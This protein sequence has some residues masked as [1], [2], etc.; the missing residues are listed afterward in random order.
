[1]CPFPFSGPVPSNFINFEAVSETSVTIFLDLDKCHVLAEEV[2]SFNLWHRVAVTESY[3]STPTVIILAPLKTFPVTGLVPATSYVFKVVAYNKSNE[4]GSWEVKKKTSCKKEDQRGLMPVGAVLEGN[5]GSPKTNSDGQSDPSSEGVDSNNNTAVCA[6]LNKSPESDFEYCENPEILDSGKASHHPGE[7]MDGLQNIQM[8]AARVTEVIELEEAPGLSASVLDEEPNPITQTAL[9]RESSN[10]EEHNQ[11]TVPPGSQDASNAPVVGNESMTVPPRY[12]GSVPPTAPRGTENGGRNFK[13]QPADSI[14][15]NG[16]S[17]PE[18][19]PGNSS[20]R[21]TGKLDDISHK[22]GC[23]E[24]SYEYCVKVVRWLECEGYIET[25]FRMKFLSWFSLRAT[26][27]E[28]KIVSV[29]V[30]TLI[31]DPVSL[32]GQLIDSFSET[33]YSNKRSSMHPGFCMALWH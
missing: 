27:H 29:Y 23:P 17:K 30:D 15:P 3:P 32:S 25:N 11:R 31:D 6:D 7:R 19:E 14:V 12:S 21:R 9:V 13:G 4:L 16:S 8:A 24:A 20:N 5:A 28:K 26:P 33:I 10:S 2:T 18:R 1:L 22:D